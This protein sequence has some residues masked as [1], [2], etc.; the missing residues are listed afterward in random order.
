[1]ANPFGPQD[2][3]T[4]TVSPEIGKP[5]KAPVV[6]REAEAEQDE[7]DPIDEVD[8][9]YWERCLA[10]A[11]RAEQ[12]WR[13]RGREII[14]I[15][16]NDGY[17]TP[18]GKKK[19]NKDIVFNVLYSNTEVMPI[20]I[21]VGRRRGNIGP[22]DPYPTKASAAPA[23]PTLTS[24]SPNTAAAGAATPQFVMK[25]IG[26]N[27]T[28]WSTILLGGI[29]A[30]SSIYSYISPTEMRCQMSPGS[31]VAGTTSVTVVDHSVATTPSLNFT[32]T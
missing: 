29:P 1:M 19:L 6:P 7:Q 22:R 20:V 21:D 4:A 15:Y 5:D 11:E 9:Q 27:F 2:K 8:T 25:L 23:V 17:Y 18:Q 12:D 13:Q 3:P 14:R 31:S 28:P 16:R 30:P 26:T 10:D 32:W 24:L